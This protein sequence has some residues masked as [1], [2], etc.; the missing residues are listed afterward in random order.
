VV[1]VPSDETDEPRRS[2]RNRRPTPSEEAR[3]AARR[4]TDAAREATTAASELRDLLAEFLSR[5]SREEA[6]DAARQATDATREATTVAS[7]ARDLLRELL[8]LT[9]RIEGRLG[10]APRGPEKSTQESP[11]ATRQPS[12]VI[13]GP[14]RL[15]SQMSVEK[16][17][18]ALGWQLEQYWNLPHEQQLTLYW[19]MRLMDRA[20]EV[21]IPQSVPGFRYLRS[22]FIDDLDVIDDEAVSSGFGLT[23]VAAPSPQDDYQSARWLSPLTVDGHQFPVQVQ[24]PIETLDSPLVRPADGSAAC[25]AYSR[26]SQARRG[27]GLL[28]AK[29]VIEDAI[30]GRIP[31][32]DGTFAAILDTAPDGIDAALVSAGEIKGRQKLQVQQLVA[33][34]ADVEFV[35]AVSGINRTK[36]KQITDTRGIFGSAYLPCRIFL[37]KSGRKGDSGALV[38]DA[39]TNAAVGIYM[40]GLRDPAGTSEGIAQHMYQVQLIMDLELWE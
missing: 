24:R 31:L 19:A 8:N 37:A 17:E 22:G 38:R 27:P 23:V 10:E 1:A 29:H 30:G 25:W 34:W 2:P 16:I 39:A 40:G 35:G 21:K 33:P 9:A 5:T 13:D 18:P 14:N 26:V 32:S 12:W 36:I 6:R 7:E 4:A 20:A 28:T 15:P 11:D 3:D